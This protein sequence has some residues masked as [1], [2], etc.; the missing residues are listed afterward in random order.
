MKP[1]LHIKD[2]KKEYFIAPEDILFVKADGNYCDIFMTQDTVYRSIR[3]QLGKL[4]G[5]IE[6]KGKAIE[7]HLERIGR[8]YVINMR[9]IQHVNQ[10]NGVAVLH[11]HKDVELKIPKVASKELLKAIERGMGKQVVTVYADNRAFSFKSFI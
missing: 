9:Y 2:G 11:A 1:Q 8:S 3:L 10:K 6:E 7:H 5:M 4:W